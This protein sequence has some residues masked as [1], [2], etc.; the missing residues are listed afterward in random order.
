M[1]HDI[2]EKRERLE[3]ALDT[4]WNFY[5]EVEQYVTD[6]EHTEEVP[7]FSSFVQSVIKEPKDQFLE[8]ID[9]SN[10]T[11]IG[12]A[13]VNCTRCPLSTSRLHAVPGKGVINAKVMI[14]GEGPGEAENISGLPFGGKS[15]AYLD[16]WLKAISL[17]RDED[18]FITN[19]VK[20]RPPENRNPTQQEMSICGVYLEKQ[21]ALVKPEVILC[22]G[23]VA[24]LYLL[25]KE[26]TL[27]SLRG[28]FH[29]YQHT[30]LLVTYHPSAVL[31]NSQLRGEVWKDLQLLAQF[32][33][34]PTQQK[35][36]R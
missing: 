5:D 29:N 8:M 24:S 10:I 19:V 16:T 18:V 25:K 21:I 20:C 4:M 1:N 22:L 17:E 31:R 13:I 12:N 11:Q 27:S 33:Q 9:S 3:T 7:D 23:K 2:E 6:T 36:N 15:G 28:T 34:L 35:G 30:P 14:V 26:T 32:L